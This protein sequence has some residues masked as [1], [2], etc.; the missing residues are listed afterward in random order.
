VIGKKENVD[1]KVLGSLGTVKEVS[2][3]DIFGY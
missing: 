2:L 1:F 3:E